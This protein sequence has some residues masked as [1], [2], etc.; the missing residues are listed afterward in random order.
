MI[1]KAFYTTAI[2]LVVRDIREKFEVKTLTTKVKRHCS[3]LIMDQQDDPEERKKVEKT[4]SD[5][6]TA[7]LAWERY[8]ASLGGYGAF[9]LMGL[10]SPWK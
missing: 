4:L 5:D 10:I 9:F 6:Y 3:K 2:Y 1:Y 8:A 7:G